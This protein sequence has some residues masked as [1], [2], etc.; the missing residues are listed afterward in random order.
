[1]KK[2][3]PF[4]LA[5]SALVSV[6]EIS[7]QTFP[8]ELQLT[9]LTANATKIEIEAKMI[10]GTT[11][12]NVEAVSV[13]IGYNPNDVY[14]DSLTSIINKYFQSKGFD[15]GSVWNFNM[16]GTY[17]DVILYSEYHP[18]FGSVPVLRNTPPV[19]CHFVFYPKSSGP[20]TTDFL[21]WQNTPTGALTYYFEANNPNLMNFS[22]ANNLQN[23]P[24]PVELTSFTAAQQGEAVVLQWITASET[25]NHGFHIQRLDAD[26]AAAAEW[27]TLDFIEGAGTTH[28]QRQYLFL[29]KDIPKDGLYRYRLKQVDFDGRF[30][31]SPEVLVHFNLRPGEFALRQNYPNPLSL[32]G[33]S[34][35][36]IGYDV[37]ERSNIRI[38]VRNML[39]QEVAVLMDANRDAGS[40]STTWLPYNLTAGIYIVTL[41]AETLESGGTEVRHMP[42]QVVR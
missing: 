2:L 9:V 12:M 41:T 27:E 15:D 39:G 23:V 5:A 29:D 6:P 24:W 1:M 36:V 17:P 11:I 38:M 8:A 18:N 10:P 14:V 4:L 22:P 26:Q 40:Y 33:G 3:L 19:L 37:A 20:G 31:Y 32:S 25:N 21:V 16:N 30:D 13:A 7:A 28:Q 34:G 35:T 42:I